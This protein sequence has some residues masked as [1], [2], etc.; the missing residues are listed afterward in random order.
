[1]KLLEPRGETMDL[2]RSRPHAETRRRG[3][4]GNGDQGSVP[5]P[6]GFP[7]AGV[8]GWVRSGCDG[9]Q[10]P[11]LG[12]GS[13]IGAMRRGWGALLRQRRRS[14]NGDQG[15]VLGPVG[16]L[17]TGR[18]GCVR[19]G[20]DGAQ[21]P[22]M[23]LVHEEWVSCGVPRALVCAVLLAVALGAVRLT[24]APAPAPAPA[25]ATVPAP[26]AAATPGGRT[27][28]EVRALIQRIGATPPAW[29][30][31]TPLNYPKTLDL[32]WTDTPGAPWDPSKNVGQFIWTTI[33]ENEGRWKEGVRFLHHLLVLHQKDPV[34]VR[35]VMG[36]LGRMYHDLHQ[37]WARA[38][39]WWEKAGDTDH[40]G[41][42]HC[43]FKLGSREMA[44][45]ILRQ[46]PTDYTR[47]CGVARLWSEIGEPEKGLAL[48][49]EAA[50]ST[51]D[52]GFLAAG[53]ICRGM[54]R[55]QEAL[56]YYRQALSAAQGGRDFKQSKERAQASLDAL[57][58]VELLDVKRVPDGV[59]RDSS[60]GYSGQV[61]VEV[62][63]AGGRI[64][65]VKVLRH[66]EKQY[67][68][69]ITETCREIVLKQGAK[70]VDATSGATITSEAILNATLKALA[71][72]RGTRDAG[73]GKQQ[74]AAGS[75]NPIPP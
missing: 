20:C 41:L 70:G 60:V 63:V 68:S 48:A 12:V 18:G 39:F 65:G 16:F 8:G 30:A 23:G 37:D 52:V 32:S 26:S 24:A 11:K 72:G 69:S 42:A 49:L 44:Q 64:A 43:Y 53:D 61:E 46:Y 28:A 1:M 3:G 22:R 9:A 27:A 25:P 54:G 10:P 35:K 47:H 67:Y 6:V 29:F 55:I 50:Q 34:L 40:L 75:T 73:Q 7:R 2:V 71:K 14:S 36:A 17:G 31:S 51:P 66:T 74:G 4:E 45:E 19:S 58:F 56:G 57:Q 15:S 62:R 13:W 5:G 38:A 33:N 59:Y 21:P